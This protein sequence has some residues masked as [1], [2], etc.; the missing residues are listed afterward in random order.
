[1]ESI[2]VEGKTP[3]EAIKKALEILRVARKDVEIKIL[4]EEKKGLFGMGGE[5][6]ARVRVTKIKRS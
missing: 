3:Q 1:M 6:P 5:K 2:E 4:S